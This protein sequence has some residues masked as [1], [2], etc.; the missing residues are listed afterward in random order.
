M[1]KR[2]SILLAG[3]LGLAMATSCSSDDDAP[4]TGGGNG[5]GNGENELIVLEGNLSSRTLTKNEKYL[6]KGQVFVREG[7]TLTIEPGTVILGDKATKGTLVIDRGGKLIAEGTANEPIVMTSV[8][9]AGQRDR[10]DWGGLVVLGRAKTNQNNPEIEGISPAVIF[11]GND[12]NDDSG[13]MK[14]LRVEF[15]GIE[16]TPN[17]ETNSITMGGVG[18]QTVLEYAMVSY[19]GDD[20]FEWFGG[21][22]D[23][24]YL[25]SLG[26]WD[27]DFDVDFGYTGRNQFGLAVR[28][29]SFADQS[30]SNGFECDN[31]PNDDVTELL[32]EGVFS[33][34]TILGPRLTSDQS[35]SSNYQHAIDLRRRTAVTIANSVFVGFPRGI[36][37]NQ[38]SVATNFENG[39]G[40]LLNNYMVAP[41]Q[42]FIKGS[43]VAEDFDLE[44]FWNETNEINTGTNF[45]SIYA[46]L[47]LRD[48]MFFGNVPNN[49]Y[50]S[51]PNFAV[52]T[53][54]L[55]SGAE[56]SH[57][58]LSDGYFDI[59]NFRGAFGGSDWTDGWAE[60]DPISK[61]Y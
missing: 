60:F 57:A 44:A 3:I 20:G 14:Y 6:I 34:F 56:F 50:P 7:Q 19:G 26:M 12:D 53:G 39:T 16:L 54:A 51:D 42:T 10:G 9:P 38:N 48:E 22:N 40:N 36:R 24:K 21:N 11:G 46:D 59:V 5:N 23:G 58:K 45:A 55:T 49:Q 2:F 1:K 27:D 41:T 29:A 4:I 17:N 8:L 43:N 13:I 33:N 47:G 61:E 25:I 31:G 52:P 15:A 37:M 28:Y 32:T 35:I 30:G 18:K